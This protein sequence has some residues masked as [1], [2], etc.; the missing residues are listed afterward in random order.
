MSKL[1][2]LSFCLEY[3]A[4][5]TGK[6]S[7]QVYMLFKEQ[8]LLDVLEQDYDDLHGMG[9][10]YLMQFFDEYLGENNDSL[11]RFDD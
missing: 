7:N 10:E 8:G 3:Y 11:P 6:P 5:H 9:M 1:S 2:F 4:E